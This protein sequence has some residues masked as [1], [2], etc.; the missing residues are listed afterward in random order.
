MGRYGTLDYPTLAKRGVVV[1]LSLLAIGLGTEFIT[2]ALH[3]QL[4]AW[5]NTL[6]FDVSVLGLLVFLFSPLVF[7]IV[8]PL[9]E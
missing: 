7:G 6:L 5:E 1:G 3:Y 8:L 4:P 9:T 2:H